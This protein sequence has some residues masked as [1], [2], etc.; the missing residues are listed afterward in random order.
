MAGEFLV[1]EDRLIKLR[2]TRSGRISY[3]GYNYQCGYAVSRLASMVTEKPLFDVTDYPK[4]LRYDWAEDLDELFDDGSVCFTQCKRANDI[5][6]PAKLADVLLGFVPKWLWTPPDNRDRIRFR[7]V[8]CDQRFRNGFNRGDFQADTLVRFKKLLETDPGRNSDQSLWQTGAAAVG[9]EPLFD[10][11]WSKFSAVYVASESIADDR[12][13]PILVSEDE[14]LHLL[15]RRG[16][17]SSWSQK[18]A[19]NDLRRLINDGLISFDPTNEQCPSL[20]PRSPISLDAADVRAALFSKK[21]GRRPPAFRVVDR[22][23]LSKARGQPKQK[24]SFGS[25]EWHHVVHGTDSDIKFVERDQTDSLR[26][27]VLEFLIQPLQ[28]GTSDLPLLFVTGAPGA[29]KTTLVR[30]VAARLVESGDAVV[31]D[32]GLNLAGGPADLESY[33]EDL[34]ELAA[35]GRPVLLVLDDPLFPGSGW[36]DLLVLLKQP[37]FPVAV[38]AATPDFLYQQHRSHLTKLSRT[39]PFV[40]G[41]PTFNEKRRFAQMYDR[42]VATFDQHF[43]DFLALVTEAESGEQLPQIMPRLWQTLNHGKPFDESTSFRE[44]PWEVRAFWFVCFF[45]RDYAHCPMATLEAA[46]KLSGGS[47]A[48]TNVETTLAKLKEQSGWHIFRIHSAVEPAGDCQAEF[49]S[50]AHQKI[51]SAAWDCRPMKWF[52][53]EVETILKD[54]TAAFEPQS[55][56]SVATAAA[57]MA[58][59]ASTSQSRVAQE[60]VARL[61]K[62]AAESRRLTTRNLCELAAVLMTNRRIDLSSLSQTLRSRATGKDGW[63]AALQLWMMSSDD[64]KRRSFPSDLDL[65][66]LIATADFSIKPHHALYLFKAVGADTALRNAIYKRL[67]ASLEGQVDWRLGPSLL[68]W[69]LSDAPPE[70]CAK[71]FRNVADS[72]R[73]HDYDSLLRTKYLKLLQA[74][75]ATFDAERKQAVVET[76]D[77]LKRHDRNAEVRTHYL[78]FL[79]GLPA[80]FDD[81]RRQSVIDTADWLKRHDDDSFVRA[82]YLSLL[83]GLPAT[84]DDQRKQA[85]IE[86][87][88]WL[89]RHDEDSYVRTQYLSF[90]VG[91]PAAFDDQRRQM[92]IETVGWIKRHDDNSNVRAQYF[93]LLLGLPAAFDDQRKQAVIETADWLRRHE[94]DSFV[95]TQYL[96]FLQELPATFDEQRIQ[97]AKETSEW[98][99]RHS[100]ANNVRSKYLKFLRFVPA[101]E[102]KPLRTASDKHHQQLIANNPKKSDFSYA[103]QLLGLGRFEDAIAQYDIVLKRHHG[104][105]VARRG[106]AFA[107]QKLGRLAEAESEFEHALFWARAHK[108][109]EAKFHT[110]LGEL[111]LETKRWHEAI[112]SFERAQEEF[113]NHFSNHRGIAKAQIGL[114]NLHQAMESLKRALEDVNLKP[115]ARDG[116][117]D[118]LKQLQRR[119]AS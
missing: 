83:Q 96:S 57:I 20:P 22:V 87:A 46:L 64:D 65:V 31:A 52:D 95:R 111:Y 82:K 104:H 80:T 60:I 48:T 23:V 70:E 25:P 75:P 106:K 103:E 107:L 102:L 44:L 116:V 4:L 45:H 63:L 39:P 1:S 112:K 26:E 40:L 119:C 11:L 17:V 42:D 84:F 49:I 115:P 10:A 101:P 67:F 54:P 13:G 24:F 86:I 76:A 97:V 69:L 85:V 12:A 93:S 16:F 72:V 27:K 37:G 59:S 91:L 9:I 33:A 56:R 68:A 81:Q 28:R 113:P 117:L 61:Q 43:D 92:V 94:N 78:K 3:A 51:A 35:E 15:L 110:S 2:A 105:E 99:E 109:S 47:G 118:L 50:V 89:K 19:I 108:V 18:D 14:A 21:E 90:L 62:A 100:D 88:E 8:S 55:I 32:A 29:G 73:R 36:I 114:G 66:G 53:K 38:I 58:K 5:G 74:L 41:R 34:Q 7:L 79:E 71:R 77:W 98:L 6:Q 30:R